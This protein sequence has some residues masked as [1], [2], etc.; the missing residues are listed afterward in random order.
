[1]RM[2]WAKRDRTY[3]GIVVG[4]DELFAVARSVAELMGPAAQVTLD[5][6][7]RHYDLQATTVDEL[8]TLTHAGDSR[9]TSATLMVASPDGEFKVLLAIGRG[10]GLRFLVFPYW[11]R[12]RT[13][14]RVRHIDPVKCDEIWQI[15]ARA[16]GSKAPG[17]IVRA[18][19]ILVMYVGLPASAA[20]WLS[21]GFG[22]LFTGHPP[23]GM[24]DGTLQDPISGELLSPFWN[25]F[26]STTFY[27][28][29]SMIFSARLISLVTIPVALRPLDQDRWTWKPSDV[30]VRRWTV[31]SGVLAGAA[32][33]VSIVLG[34]V[35][36]V[37]S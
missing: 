37:L 25:T 30:S 31:L 7:E 27:A 9:F 29:V 23:N 32:I 33:I 1:M 2:R 5:A 19:W 6:T 10:L 24:S 12:W 3:V 21:V 8:Q 34:V 17:W 11:R 4:V 22:Q 15:G 35:P 26:A 20:L 36:H 16:L 14:L 13:D 28:T 18:L